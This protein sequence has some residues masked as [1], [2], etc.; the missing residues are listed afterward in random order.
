MLA[1]VFALAMMALAL[2]GALFCTDG[3]DRDEV[4]HHQT[5]RIPC[6]GCAT[7][8]TGSMPELSSPG[9]QQ[10]VVADILPRDQLPPLTGQSTRIEHPPRTTQS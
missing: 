6:A 7:C 9:P 8:Q 3:C 4:A 10:L 2:D 1:L 5:T